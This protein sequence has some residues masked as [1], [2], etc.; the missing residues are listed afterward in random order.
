M[1]E[2]KKGGGKDEIRGWRDEGNQK[3][4]KRSETADGGHSRQMD[5]K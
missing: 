3:E 1:R 4:G 5:E 2:S